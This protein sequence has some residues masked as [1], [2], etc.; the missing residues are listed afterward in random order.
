[1]NFNQYIW[2]VIAL[3]VHYHESSFDPNSIELMITSQ[4]G[5]VT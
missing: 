2:Y 3:Y 5:K 4:R 1:M